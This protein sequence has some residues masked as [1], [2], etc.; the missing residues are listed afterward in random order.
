MY[1]WGYLVMKLFGGDNCDITNPNITP[2]IGRDYYNYSI[3]LGCSPLPKY[4]H[5]PPGFGNP[6]PETFMGATSQN[7]GERATLQQANQPSYSQLMR[8]RDG[9]NHPITETHT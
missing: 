4:N 6:K 8:S 2:R 7:P 5:K 9:P 1:S 3:N